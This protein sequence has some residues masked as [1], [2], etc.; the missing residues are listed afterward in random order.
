MSQTAKSLVQTENTNSATVYSLPKCRQDVVL[1]AA[2]L[3]F[4]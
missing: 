3:V 1:Q 4:T 2:N